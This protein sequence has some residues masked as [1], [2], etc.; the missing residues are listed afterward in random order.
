MCD[1]MAMLHRFLLL[2]WKELLQGVS[3]FDDKAAFSSPSENGGPA[4]DVRGM[5][6][7]VIAVAESDGETQCLKVCSDVVQDRPSLRSQAKQGYAVS[8]ITG[9]SRPTILKL[10]ATPSQLL[11]HFFPVFRHLGLS[12]RL[13][14]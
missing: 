9:T 7:P 2:S 6:S 8:S 3:G 5:H 11:A 4:S 14:C 13:A 1:G 10:L 12:W